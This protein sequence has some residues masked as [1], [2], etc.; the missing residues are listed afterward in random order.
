M[1]RRREPIYWGTPTLL[2]FCG[3][4]CQCMKDSHG[5]LTDTL[6]IFEFF[7]TYTL[8][9]SYQACAHYVHS[10]VKI[11]LH[12]C[13]LYLLLILCK[14]YFTSFSIRHLLY[15]LVCDIIATDLKHHVKSSNKSRN[16]NSYCSQEARHDSSIVSVFLFFVWQSVENEWVMVS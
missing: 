5:D 15:I 11:S 4:C 1:G 7:I 6:C 16:F 8:V 2:G 13:H 3:S 14:V 12:L 10:Y 9:Y